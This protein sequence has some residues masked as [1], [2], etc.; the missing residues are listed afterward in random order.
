MD[1][2][3]TLVGQLT[4]EIVQVAQDVHQ[5][6]APLFA[7]AH[8]HFESLFLLQQLHVFLLQLFPIHLFMKR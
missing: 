5:G 4:I 8:A 3:F 1:H 2:R 7:L 6:A